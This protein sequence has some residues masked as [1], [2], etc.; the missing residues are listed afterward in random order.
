MGT[1]NNDDHTFCIV[2]ASLHLTYTCIYSVMWR[3]K[4]SRKFHESR[5]EPFTYY[6]HM[7]VVYMLH[8][9]EHL[10][11]VHYNTF[12]LHLHFHFVSSFSPVP[13]LLLPLL[14]TVTR[15]T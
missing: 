1:S 13:S 12:I 9:V 3:V 14:L 6:C 4:V 10:I 2:P 11:Y 5:M 8:S 15:E 7:A